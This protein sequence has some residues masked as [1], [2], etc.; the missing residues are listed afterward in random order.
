MGDALL[1]FPL[2]E[3]SVHLCVDMQRIFSADGPWP[4][5]WMEKVLL[6]VATLAGRHPGRTVFTR[7]IPP[8]RPDQMPGMWQRYYTRWR[9]ATREFLNLDL[10]ELKPPLAALC[11][12]ATVIDKMR[13]SGFAEPRLLAHLRERAADALIVS[14]SETDVCVLATVLSAVDLGYRVII[15]RDAVCSSSDEG[16]DMLL[17]LY[18]TRFSEQIETADAE[19][20]LSQWQ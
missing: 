7:F 19:T 15:A 6:V 10:L 9:A 4:A 5:P 20:I 11:P 2:T 12:P 17:R 13:Y 16:H 14:G 1:P 8:E 18:H 3:R